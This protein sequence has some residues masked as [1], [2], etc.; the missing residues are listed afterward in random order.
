MRYILS[1]I[2]LLVASG[3]QALDTPNSRFSCPQLENLQHTLDRV[4]NVMQIYNLNTGS[5]IVKDEYGCF[6]MDPGRTF[7]YDAAEAARRGVWG[8]H[9]VGFWGFL[10]TKHFWVEVWRVAHPDEQI[11]VRGRLTKMGDQVHWTAGKL[12][13]VEEAEPHRIC[14]ERVTRKDDVR[15]YGHQLSFGNVEDA[16]QAKF[17][18][19]AP[20]VRPE[21]T[22][23]HHHAGEMRGR[24]HPG[25]WDRR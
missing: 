8:Y 1:L 23:D 12:Y 4:T 14:R 10:K 2:L 20:M 19:Q 18:A 25:D 15:V 3:A 11:R 6:I 17:C 16:W 9:D 13:P 5:D 7:I 21:R 22:P 24:E